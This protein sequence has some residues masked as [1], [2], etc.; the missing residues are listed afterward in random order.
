MSNIGSFDVAARTSEFVGERSEINKQAVMYAM[1]L[2]AGVDDASWS[3]DVTITPDDG[4]DAYDVAGYMTESY[5]ST[6]YAELYD[7]VGGD[8]DSNLFIGSDGV[9]NLVDADGVMNASA[10]S[11]LSFVT[12]LLSD[13]I[14]TGS[15]LSKSVSTISSNAARDLKQALNQIG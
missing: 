3:A 15:A 7:Y 8:S 9:T 4:G 5:L 10:S 2:T 1:D 14:T 11:A 13:E 12:G 6:E